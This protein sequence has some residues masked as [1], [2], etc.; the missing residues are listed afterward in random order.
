M[1]SYEEVLKAMQERTA[2]HIESYAQHRESRFKTLC[3]EA[4]LAD[5][6]LDGRRMRGKKWREFF[7]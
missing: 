7:K 5:I 4:E 2:K 3:E 6:Q 1:K